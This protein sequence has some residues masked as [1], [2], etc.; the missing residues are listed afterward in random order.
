MYEHETKF[1]KLT[2]TDSD[3]KTLTPQV[4]MIHPHPQG[5]LQTE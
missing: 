2:S 3:Y 5:L 4:Q 1:I